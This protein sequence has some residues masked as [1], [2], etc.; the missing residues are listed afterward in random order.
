MIFLN[1]FDRFTQPVFRLTRRVL[2]FVGEK[3]AALLL[4]GL[5]RAALILLYRPGAPR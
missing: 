4:P 1:V 3:W 2:P 5:L